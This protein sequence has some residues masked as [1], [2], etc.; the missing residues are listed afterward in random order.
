VVGATTVHPTIGCRWEWIGGGTTATCKHDGLAASTTY[1]VNVSTGARDASALNTPMTAARVFSFTTA[2]APHTLAPAITSSVPDSNAIGVSRYTS[3]A[4]TFNEAV[5]KA[6]AQG[7]FDVSPITA[8]GGTFSWSADG[9]TMSYA[10][11]S[12]LAYGTTVTW[13]MG[14][15]LKCLGGINLAAPVTRSFR[16][17]RQGSVTLYPDNTLSGYLISNQTGTYLNS[18]LFAG[19]GTSNEYYRSFLTFSLAPI[20]SA[21][22]INSATLWIYQDSVLSDPYAALGPSLYAQSVDYGPTFTKSGDMETPLLT[23]TIFKCLGIPRVCGTYTLDD[24]VAIVTSN[25]AANWYPGT[26]TGKVER[27]RQNAA[28]RGYRVQFRLKFRTDT[29]S[30]LAYNYARFSSGAGSSRPYLDVVY[31]YP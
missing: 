31:E 5:D 20:S 27:D 13:T 22:L 3:I 1:T 25:T 9:R 29:N 28:T 23:Y 10:L 30:N 14:T 21:T 17:I 15:G 8:R 12:A 7:A 4:V 19:D 6:T 26:V 18:Y 24:E 16:A 2:A 11:P